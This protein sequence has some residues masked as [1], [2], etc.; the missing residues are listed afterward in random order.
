LSEY[1]IISHHGAVDG[2]T[3]S[4]HELA[5]D[6]E[7]SVLID[8][9]LFQ[10]S[11]VSGRGAGANQLDIE[12]PVGQIKALLVTHVHID[13]VGRIP[14]LLAAGFNG[15]IYCSEP[16]ALLLPLV[17]EDAVKVGGFTRDRKLI[18]KFVKK[19]KKHIRPIP[20]KKWQAVNLE[21]NGELAIRFQRAGHILGSAYI[22]C[23]T[24]INSETKI[25][26]FSGDLGAPY[27]PLLTA[28][29]APQAAHTVV[30]ESTY[31]DRNHEGRKERKQKLKLALQH[32]LADNGVVMIP[33]FSIGRT[34]EL[35][36]E[37]EELIYKLSKQKS[38]QNLDWSRLPIIVDS[39]LAAR[40]TRVY[41]RLKPYWN[42]E[43]KQRLGQGRHPLSFKQLITIDSHKQHMDLVE[44][45]AASPSPCVVLA[46]SG[47]CA[48][49]RI[50]NYLNALIEDPRNDIIFVGYQ[51]RGT[52]GN[53]I[54]R[55]GPANGY[56]LLDGKKLAINANITTLGG[57]SAHADQ[58]NLIN[59]I[60]RMRRLPSQ[61]RVVHGDQESKHVLQQKLQ[62]ISKDRGELMEVIIPTQ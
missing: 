56:V 22:E 3:G 47:M 49:G 40:F 61:V 53:V 10:G 7:N 26:V 27:A 18:E 38:A 24:R 11:E 48:G 30:I 57:Y 43:A 58:S 42:D 39:P 19:L 13:H 41:R 8:C 1:P 52:T 12:F 21:G 54:Q 37:L 60:K 20:Y 25:T 34:Q 46:A 14:Y 16:S 36:Y 5:L 44:M 59:F 45:L 28:P 9:G 15:P 50:V 2:V 17:L 29:K 32:A 33:A 62:Q 55:Y 51:A 6:P 35:L 23:R 31:G 4:C